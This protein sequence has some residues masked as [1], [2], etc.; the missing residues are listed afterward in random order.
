MTEREDIGYLLGVIHN[1]ADH[2]ATLTGAHP[3]QTS[4]DRSSPGSRSTPMAGKFML[5]VLSDRVPNRLQEGIFIDG[6][7]LSNQPPQCAMW[8]LDVDPDWDIR[9]VREVVADK[10][11][12]VACDLTMCRVTDAYQPELHETL[13]GLGIKAD[14]PRPAFACFT[15]KAVWKQCQHYMRR[16]SHFEQARRLHEARSRSPR[17][18]SAG[19]TA[20]DGGPPTGDVLRRVMSDP[21]PVGT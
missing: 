16:V 18:S 8:G 1:A 19:S 3:A 5:F 20:R 10:L 7:Q 15:T 12:V 21:L 13:Q 6:L 17:A 4:N 9:R 14:G 2:V 11:E